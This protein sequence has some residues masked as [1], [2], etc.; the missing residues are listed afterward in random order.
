LENEFLKLE[1]SRRQPLNRVTAPSTS[2][3]P[4]IQNNVSTPNQTNVT[5]SD[6][7]NIV[8]EPAR[9][10]T[11]IL[12]DNSFV[13]TVKEMLPPFDGAVNS[14]TP[15]N[16]WIAQLNAIIKMYKLN[17]DITRMMVMSMLKDRTQIWLHSS[18]NFL[19]LPVQD[20]LTQLAEAF[21]SK[22][23]KIMSIMATS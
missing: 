8:A 15:V 10:I 1:V 6:F 18:E 12:N 7:G 14:Q 2:N 11:S 20:L 13:T 9:P 5:L 23:S 3:L 21:Q 4:E 19:S 17:E 22:E 16:M